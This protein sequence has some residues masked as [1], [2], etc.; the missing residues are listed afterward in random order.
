MLLKLSDARSL[1]FAPGNEREKLE[2]ALESDA[3]AVIADL[4]DAVL[5]SEKERA[6]DVVLEAFGR[7]SGRAVRLVRINSARTRYFA[8]DLVA[9]SS[10]AFDGIVLPKATTDGV[11]AIGADTPPVVAIVET[12]E[13]LAGARELAETPGV[14][15][16]LLGAVDLGRELGLERRGDGLELV[17]PRAELV[18]ASALAGLRAPIDAVFTDVR[19]QDGLEE[20]ARRGRSLGMRGKAC[21]H[22]AQ[23]EV[24]NRVFAPSEQEIE[25][26]HAMIEAY[27]AAESTGRGSV[28]VDGELV[29]LP[30]LER[31]RAVLAEANRRRDAK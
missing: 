9:I 30:V 5:P 29:D 27:E 21:I 13:G 10:A 22:P 3:D 25:R 18:L 11:A 4:E 31:A 28:A 12:A 8:D 14:A 19:D 1:L 17:H 7:G 6:R 20:D 15:A 23:I 26:A 16:L 24:V 2:R